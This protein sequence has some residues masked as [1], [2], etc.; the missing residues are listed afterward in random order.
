MVKKAI[1][2]GIS[3]L[4]FAFAGT[5]FAMGAKTIVLKGGMMGDVT[6][7]HE[8]HQKSLKDCNLCH[9]LFPMK[10]GA[11]EKGI[12][13]GKLKKKEVMKNCEKCHKADK[14]AG[15]PAGPTSCKG[16]HKK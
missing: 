14:A 9:K 4:S 12:A 10:A 6:F 2:I 1:I 5:A 13:D 7:P 11:I 8:A 3:V 16:C 15:K